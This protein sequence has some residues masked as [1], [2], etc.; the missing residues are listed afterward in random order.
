MAQH[1]WPT[2]RNIAGPNNV[3]TCCIR[4]HGTTIMLA[5]VAYS[6]KP[7]KLLAQ[8]V[9]TFLLFCDRRSIAQQCCVCL[10]GTPTMLANGGLVKMSAHVPCNLFFKNKQS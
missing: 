6:L 3:V 2:T 9:Q 8:Q 1:C 7:V 5:L 4:L 10:H